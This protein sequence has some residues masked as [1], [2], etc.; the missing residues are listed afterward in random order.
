MKIG[1]DLNI[2][3]ENLLKDS[4]LTQEVNASEFDAL[5][6]SLITKLE[7]GEISL[8][9][10]L[11]GEKPLDE[12]VE[13]LLGGELATADQLVLREIQLNPQVLNEAIDQKLETLVQKIDN[14][15]SSDV[16]TQTPL[17]DQTQA[18]L[19]PLNGTIQFNE[20]AITNV[21]SLLVTDDKVPTDD[22]MLVKLDKLRAL[23][24]A[25][26]TV[27]YQKVDVLPKVNEE[28]ILQDSIEEEIETG[29]L[30]EISNVFELQINQFQ[31]DLRVDSTTSS[32][33][34]TISNGLQAQLPLQDIQS[35][36]V[37]STTQL[38]TSDIQFNQYNIVNAIKS[39]LQTSTSEGLHKLTVRLHPEELG[40]INI[41]LNMK[42][43][44]VS[45]VIRV[46]EDQA[47]A[48]FT[49]NLEVIKN[50]L[51][52]QGIKVE[53]LDI[54]LSNDNS[55]S[56]AFRDDSFRNFRENRDQ[57]NFGNQNNQDE[58]IEAVTRKRVNNIYREEGRV[59][60]LI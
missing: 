36:V 2:S 9:D 22:N 19:N 16:T 18:E 39:Q 23:L 37:S 31:R 59:N 15:L 42:D 46:N 57:R 55:N 25:N 5:L 29:T 48:V 58:K 56:N 4:G 38:T 8:E 32:E 50:E 45:G 40:R 54:N 60:M 6:S 7:N 41:E 53:S 28:I 12:S 52:S 47:K 44:I 21:E 11:S 30:P 27:E 35:N 1:V 26:D 3:V 49:E 51:Q 14:E 10:L 34:A 33:V 24:S 20:E 43:G 13:L 17:I